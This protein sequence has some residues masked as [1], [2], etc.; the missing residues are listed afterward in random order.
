MTFLHLIPWAPGSFSAPRALPGRPRASSYA[1]RPLGGLEVPSG[2]KMARIPRA[3]VYKYPIPSFVRS[4]CRPLPTERATHSSPL[5]FLLLRNSSSSALCS[6]TNERDWQSLP[7]SLARSLDAMNINGNRW[8]DG[9]EVL[10]FH[11]FLDPD[12]ESELPEVPK[13]VEI[14]LRSWIQGRNHNTSSQNIT[15]CN[16]ATL[17]M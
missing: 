8:I 9:L 11:F 15:K 17:E 5:L 2:R 6:I 3:E 7:R 4:F 1:L 16:L 13:R 14:R 10:R 12:P